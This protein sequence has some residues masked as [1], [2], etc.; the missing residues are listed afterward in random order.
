MNLSEW[1]TLLRQQ[2]AET[3]FIQWVALALGVSEVLFARANKIWLYPTGIGA[4]SLSIFILF[5]AGLY[6]E[7]LLNGYY[8]VMS[9]YGWWYWIKK[10]MS[11]P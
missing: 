11:R 6:A 4:T 5:E 8:I 9:V 3:P 10:E 7:C 1:I 2:L